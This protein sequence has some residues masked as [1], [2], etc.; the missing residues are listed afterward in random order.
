MEAQKGVYSS[1][2]L[3]D[4]KGSFGDSTGLAINV[5]VANGTFWTQQSLMNTARNLCHERNRARKYPVSSKGSLLTLDSSDPC[6][7]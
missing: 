7:P 5:D 6:F 1:M 2:R 3:N 4:P